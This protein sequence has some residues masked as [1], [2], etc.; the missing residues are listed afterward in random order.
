MYVWF[1]LNF[2][3]LSLADLASEPYTIV[4]QTFKQEN[5]SAGPFRHWHLVFHV[6]NSDA[7]CMINDPD[8]HAGRKV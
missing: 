7:L 5:A 4:T 8:G 2:D 1:D 3:L 6:F